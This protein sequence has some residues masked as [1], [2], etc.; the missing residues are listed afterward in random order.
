MNH[1]SS[2][3][4]LIL[5]INNKKIY[6]YFKRNVKLWCRDKEIVTEIGV[7]MKETEKGHTDKDR[8]RE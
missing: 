4:T 3:F 6:I 8:K 7:E 5:I 2:S 1:V